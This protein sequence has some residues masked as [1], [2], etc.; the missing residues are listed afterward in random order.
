LSNVPAVTQQ[1]LQPVKPE[2]VTSFEVG[3]KSSWF[4]RRLVLDGSLFYNDYRDMQLFL[5]A[6]PPTT[7][8]PAPNPS[9][10]N[11][12]ANNILSNADAF[13]AG[14]DISVIANPFDG[15][16]AKTDVGILTTKIMRMVGNAAPGASSDLT[17]EQLTLSPHMSMST[18]LD[19]NRDIPGGVLDLQF[20]VNYKGHQ[21]FD[22]A[23]FQNG[24]TGPFLQDPYTQQNG[25]WLLNARASYTFEDGRWEVAVFGRNLADKQYYLDEF[26]LQNPFGFIQGV[27]GMPRVIGGEVDFKY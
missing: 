5:L 16:T 21:F 1:Q 7:I 3:A 13:T 24:T 15:F 26:N 14:S 18:T 10:P 23:K 9:N 20:N 17:D 12:L 22:L 4:D 8:C 6:P 11:C 27:V 19:Y 25:Y 2:Y